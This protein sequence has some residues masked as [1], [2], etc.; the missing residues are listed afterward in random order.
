MLTEDQI[1]SL[2]LD[3]QLE[4]VCQQMLGIAGP[5]KVDE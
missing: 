4:V 5:D 1:N 3:G 2:M